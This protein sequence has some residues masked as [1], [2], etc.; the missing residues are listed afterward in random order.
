MS[1]GFQNFGYSS[2][3]SPSNLDFKGIANAATSIFKTKKVKRKYPQMVTSS[4]GEIAAWNSAAHT[5]QVLRRQARN[6]SYSK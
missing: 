1:I 5:R 3:F 2:R 6:S 4:I